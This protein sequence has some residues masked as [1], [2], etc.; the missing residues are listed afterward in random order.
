MRHCAISIFA[1]LSCL[2]AVCGGVFDPNQADGR[3]LSD[4]HVVFSARLEFAEVPTLPDVDSP[5]GEELMRAVRKVDPNGAAYGNIAQLGVQAIAVLASV[6]YSA[7]MTFV[8]LKLIDL[9]VGLRVPEQEEVL[10]L[11][12]S[13]HRETAYQI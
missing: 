11:D 9:F 7:V 8:I 4:E 2:S 1:S 13:Q 5:R 6:T 10:G 12:A 3:V